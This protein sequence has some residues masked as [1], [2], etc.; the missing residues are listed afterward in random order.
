[1]INIKPTNYASLLSLGALAQKHFFMDPETLKIEFHVLPRNRRIKLVKRVDE[2]EY[3]FSE[4]IEYDFDIVYCTRFFSETD[5]LHMGYS[6]KFNTL[7]V[8]LKEEKK[9]GHSEE[10]DI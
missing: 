1:M 7:I 5:T 6:A 4:I 3:L 9:N 8:C 10:T 2:R